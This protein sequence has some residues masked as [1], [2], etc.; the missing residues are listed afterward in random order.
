M[1]HRVFALLAMALALCGA[2]TARA[3]EAVGVRIGVTSKSESRVVIDLRSP[4]PLS[5]SGPAADG[6]TYTIDFPE[7][8]VQP[9]EEKGAGLVAVYAWTR[10]DAGSRLT[11]RLAVEGGLKANFEIAA[12]KKV[13]NHRVVLDFV[14]RPVLGPVAAA[15][16]PYEDLTET[17]KAVVPPAPASITAEPS[18]TDVEAA[19]PPAR[20]RLRVVVIDPGHGGSDPGAH[21]SGGVQEKAVTLAAAKELSEILQK[22]GRYQIVLTR[23]DDTRLVLEQRAKVARDA[24]ADLFISL[25]ADANEDVAVRGGSIYTLSEDGTERAAREAQSSGDYHNVY[26]EDLEK[27][28][29]ELGP[30][31][32]D[33][34]QKTTLT[35]SARFADH[36]LRRVKGVTP[37]LNNSHRVADLRVLLSPDVP[38]VLFELAFISNDLDAAN[39]TSAKW[40]TNTMAAVA[41]AIDAYFAQPPEA[42]QAAGAASG[43]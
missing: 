29:P 34:A 9:G 6:K 13:P 3:A 2:T 37:L 32:Y 31:L 4:T 12:T 1:R 40:R 14:D 30:I 17:L 18:P 8:S 36:L 11:I 24:G 23:A 39:L 26:G 33:L 28:A 10:G 20:P 41:D 42:R 43:R 25:H 22:R 19:V 21:S 35:R 15:S 5:V 38:A 16:P 7:L 27:H